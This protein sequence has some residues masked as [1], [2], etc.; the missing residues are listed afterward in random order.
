[1]G[2]PQH[3][4]NLIIKKNPKLQGIYSVLCFCAPLLVDGLATYSINAYINSLRS[5]SS[6]GSP[7]QEDNSAYTGG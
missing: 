2:H 4:K 6:P 1:M 3:I 7:A 5:A